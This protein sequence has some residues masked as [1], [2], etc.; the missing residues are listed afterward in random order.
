ML[1]TLKAETDDTTGEPQ[2]ILT[3]ACQALFKDLG[4]DV[5]TVA[6]AVAEVK[7]NPSGPLAK[8]IQDG[9]ER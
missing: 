6:E 5:Q 7:E 1:L 8:A 4:C 2:Q 3:P 9:I